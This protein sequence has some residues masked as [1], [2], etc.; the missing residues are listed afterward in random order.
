MQHGLQLSP[1]V[2]MSCLEHRCHLLELLVQLPMMPALQSRHLLCHMHSVCA[3]VLVA[4]C[5]I[6]GCQSLE[7]NQGG[8]NCL[9]RERLPRQGS[10]VVLDAPRSHCHSGCAQWSRGG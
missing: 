7:L 5:I 3:L 10:A 9:S 1:L 8:C 4:P 2:V 6:L